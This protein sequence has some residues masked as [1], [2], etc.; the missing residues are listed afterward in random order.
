VEAGG[1]LPAR[2][3]VRLAAEADKTVRLSAGGAGV[4][5]GVTKVPDWYEVPIAGASFDVINNVGSRLV[6]GGY[7]GDRGFLER[8]V[9]QYEQPEDVFAWCGAAVLLSVRFL[10]DVG[11][12]DGRYFVYYED[13]DLSWRGRL[14]GWRYRYVPNS[15]VRHEH[16]A[17]SKEGSRLFQH[18]VERNRFLTLVR[19]APWSMVIEA[20]YVFLRDTLVIL[21]RDVVKR[22]V[23]GQV[24]HP[25]TVLIRL[26]AF[27]AFVK[28]SG[29][30]LADRARQHARPGLR[31]AIVRAWAVPQ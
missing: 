1:Q 2:V 17:T 30:T 26:R 31:S 3:C 4:E 16:A 6:R 20:L 8:D 21:K 23:A 5:V 14:A 13:T 12:F 24:P 22:V 10:R 27:L 25:R 19:N 9:G 29:P 7:G 18:Y 15:V 11:V 28:L